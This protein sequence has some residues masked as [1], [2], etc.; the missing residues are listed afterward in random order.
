MEFFWTNG[1]RG[2]SIGEL[3]SATGV[4]RASLY[5][6]YP[7]KRELFIRSIEQYLTDVVEGHLAYLRD[8]EDPGEA[9]RQFLLH[10]LDVP[11]AEL[12]RGCMLG[13]AAAEIG[14]RDKRAATL[15][16]N[17]L[18][19]VED[20]LYARLVEARAAGVLAAGVQP[21]RYARELIALLQGMRMMGRVGFDRA[22]LQDA[23]D[24]ALASIGRPAATGRRN[25]PSQSSRRT[26]AKKSAR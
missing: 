26:A 16:R 22:T 23:L 21:R 13:N 15:I 19:S 24:A 2:T 10:F 12:R 17:A 11:P 14:L 9:V 3:V 6:A 18:K 4:N 1:Y 25:K 5:S 20:S 8:I 7:D